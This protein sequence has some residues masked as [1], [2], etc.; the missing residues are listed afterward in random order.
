MRSVQSATPCRIS[1]PARIAY[2]L[3]ALVLIAADVVIG[4][5]AW[6]VS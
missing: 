3:V 6:R 1:L 5:V 4:Y 2:A